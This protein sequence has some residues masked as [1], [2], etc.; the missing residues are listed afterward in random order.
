[1][2]N[3]LSPLGSSSWLPANPPAV[4]SRSRPATGESAQTLDE[5]AQRQLRELQQTDRTVRAHEAAHL[6]AAGGLANGGASYTMTRG[7]DGRFYATGGEV[8]ISTSPGGTPQ[9]TVERAR[10]IRAAALAP[11]QPSAQDY[12]VAAQAARME[13]TAQLELAAQARATAAEEGPP[14]APLAAAYGAPP[15]AGGLVDTEA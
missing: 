1:M 12:R 4:P 5:E 15:I 2:V 3:G 9:D 11:A 7:P 8:S 10:R 6:S 13:A 14:R